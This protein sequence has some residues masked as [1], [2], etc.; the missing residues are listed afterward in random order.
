MSIKDNVNN[1]LE[2]VELAAK[3]VN[4][5]LDDITVIAVSKTV[6]AD[7]ALEAVN[8]GL[9]NLGENRVQEFNNKFEKINNNN[10]N[11]HIIGHLQKNKVK[12]IIGKVKLIHSLESVSLAEEINKRSIQNNIMTEVLVEMNIGQEESKF[13][14]KEEEL[15]NFLNSIKHLSNIKI[16]GLMTVAPYDEDKEN[17]RWVFRKMKELYNVVSNSSYENVKMKYL[18]MGMT[19]DFDIA[20]EEGANIVRIGTAIFGKRNYN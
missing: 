20:I 16:V 9:V 7:K 1:I 4:K 5:T 19:N 17:V 12:Y 18:S 8:S 15:T 3:K 11:W 13:G 2:R 14:L 10:I 6:D